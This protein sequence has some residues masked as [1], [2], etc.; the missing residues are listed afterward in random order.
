MRITNFC[1]SI[2]V[3]LCQH[4]ANF[5][6]AKLTDA[7]TCTKWLCS[8]LANDL[9]FKSTLTTAVLPKIINIHLSLGFLLFGFGGEKKDD[10]CWS[11]TALQLYD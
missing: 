4:I 3:D 2:D 8:S 7:L 6:T 1:F 11:F 10:F 9:D 5:C